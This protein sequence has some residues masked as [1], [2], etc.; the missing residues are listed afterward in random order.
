LIG[1]LDRFMRLELSPPPSSFSSSVTSPIL[2]SFY[3]SSS[4]SAF[5]LI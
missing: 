1:V 4:Q 2:M 3:L 5:H